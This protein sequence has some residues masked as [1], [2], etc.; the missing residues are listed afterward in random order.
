MRPLNRKPVS[1]S[2][3]ARTFRSNTSRTKVANIKGAP[4]RGGI[5]L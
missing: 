5:R 4:M 1:K 3:S 2:G